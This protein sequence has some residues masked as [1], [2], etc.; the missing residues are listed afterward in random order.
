MSVL[1][2]IVTKLL[3]MFQ[4]TSVGKLI[5]MSYYV[6]KYLHSAQSFS[7]A[8]SSSVKECKVCLITHLGYS[9]I[10]QWIS[11]IR[12]VYFFFTIA[13]SYYFML[14]YIHI[15]KNPFRKLNFFSISIIWLILMLPRSISCSF[16]TI[17]CKAS[18]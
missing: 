2:H 16:H 18:K 17:K 15:V 8:N 14:N 6:V 5:V 4:Y 7:M 1:L 9:I 10:A 11:K 12:V 13:V 3:E